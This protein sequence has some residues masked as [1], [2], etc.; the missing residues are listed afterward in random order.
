MDRP[1]GRADTGRYRVSIIV[2]SDEVAPDHLLDAII[3]MAPRFHQLCYGADLFI[4]EETARVVDVDDAA[5][6]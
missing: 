4:D 2:E 6:G 1:I 3:E 5:M